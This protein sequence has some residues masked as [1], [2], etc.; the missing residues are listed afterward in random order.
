MYSAASYDFGQPC[1]PPTPTQATLALA[2]TVA[3]NPWGSETPPA[4]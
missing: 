1:P 3:H 2:D 4:P